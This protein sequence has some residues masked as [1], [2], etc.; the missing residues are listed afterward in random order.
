M[1]GL[2]P[3]GDILSLLV[4]R[5]DAKKAPQYDFVASRRSRGALRPEMSYVLWRLRAKVDSGIAE[6]PIRRDRPDPLERPAREC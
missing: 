5:K 4:Q 1:P 6:T 3:A 2:A